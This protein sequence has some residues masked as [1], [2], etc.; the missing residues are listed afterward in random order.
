MSYLN[1]G[2]TDIFRC[3]LH[4]T[5]AGIQLDSKDQNIIQI[6]L[7]EFN[8]DQVQKKYFFNN[9]NTMF[10]NPHEEYWLNSD[11]GESTEIKQA[12]CTFICRKRGKYVHTVI[13]L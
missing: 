2:T 10:P 1:S 4:K 7:P 5:K 12:I 6:A 3:A 13:S 9:L 11:T 8:D